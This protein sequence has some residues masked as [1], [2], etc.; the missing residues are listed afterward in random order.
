MRFPQTAALIAT[1]GEAILDA[2]LAHED[3]HALVERRFQESVMAGVQDLKDA[4]NSAKTSFDSLV[5]KVGQSQGGIDPSDLDPVL[6]EVND[7]KG[8]IDD[9]I[10][11]LPSK[12]E[13]ASTGTS[14]PSV[15]T[16][17]TPAAANVSGAVG[18]LTN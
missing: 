10:A 14:D 9:V 13:G 5:G 17:G 12:T 8:K 4:L 15:G 18:S 16:A 2:I 6:A 11:S 7:L 1:E 3:F